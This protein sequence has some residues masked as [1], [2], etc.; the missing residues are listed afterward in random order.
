M[1]MDK[2]REYLAIVAVLA[3]Y[4]HLTLLNGVSAFSILLVA[5]VV[6]LLGNLLRGV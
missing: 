3:V 2:K 6:L 5:Y 1:A 4:G